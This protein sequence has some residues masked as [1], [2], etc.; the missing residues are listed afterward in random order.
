MQLSCT[1]EEERKYVIYENGQR[2][3]A[4]SLAE[5]ESIP[6]YER[7]KTRIWPYIM[8]VNKAHLVM[9]CEQGILSEKDTGCI[10]HAVEN[11]DYDNYSQRQFTGEFEDM[12]FE[13]EYE[14]IEKSYGLGG[15]M[16]LA[17]SR[18]D[19]CIAWSHMG[20]RNQ[21]LAT[22]QDLIR[23]QNTVRVFAEQQKDTLYV[24]HT[25]TQHAQPGKFGHYFLGFL[26]VIDRCI[27]RFRYAY[28]TT[29]VSPMGAAAVTTTGFP[30]SRERVCE[31]L[32]F[33]SV[34]E[35]SIDAIGNNDYYL[36]SMS[37]VGLCALDIG[38]TITDMVL[39]ATEEEKMIK[40]AKEYSSTSSIMP[41]KSNP[42]ALEHL[43]ASLS[44]VK[45]L[46][47]AVV[48][49]FMKTPYGD[50]SDYED[51]DDTAHEAFDLLKKNI[52]VFNAVLATL[53]VNKEL[54]KQR[55]M[56][57]FSL[58]TEIADEMYRSYH[59]PFRKAHAFVAFMVGRAEE[60]EYNLKNLSSDFFAECYEEYFGEKFEQEFAPIKRSID[61]IY[62]VNSR[63]ILGGTGIKVMAQ[64]L[65]TAERKIENNIEWFE[66][67]EKHLKNSDEKLQR[68][69]DNL[70]R[71]YTT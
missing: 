6:N 68:E 22:T 63:E 28:D 7:S 17:R 69:V 10:L 32:G 16:H 2:Y 64:M 38:R 59:I 54:L 46:A 51:I 47:D 1:Y 8:A 58:V 57:S 55:A 35:N 29:N 39:W 23:L 3:P 45:G 66:S 43:R 11:L 67:K 14:I 33:D 26:D 42:I 31:L 21:I 61:P 9:L 65:Q 56:E 60:K 4:K 36:S 49:G 44:I 53:E 48:M 24:I 5:L 15:N 25:H 62:F 30:I 37:A 13:T 27:H 70:I 52:K 18:N 71:K 19:M 50:I 40:V 20:I 34:I 41:Q 12:Y